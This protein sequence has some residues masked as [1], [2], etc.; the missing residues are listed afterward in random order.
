MIANL[1]T[2]LTD[3]AHWSGSDGIPARI[4]EHLEYSGIAVLIALL[5]AVPAGLYIGHTGRGTVAVASVANALRALPT[6]GLLVLAVLLL[7]PRLSGNLGFQ[8][9]S[10]LVLVIL[11]IPPILTSTYAG[12]Q[13]VDPSARDA[14]YGIGMT[15]R[16]VLWQVEL[17]NSLPLM[18]SGFRSAVLQVVATATVA[19][20]VSLGGL[21]R[22]VIDG[23]QQRDYPQ[24]LSGAVLVALLAVVLDVLLA[25]VQRYAIP[26]GLTGRYRRAPRRPALTASPEP[27]S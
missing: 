21:G 10:I 15:G 7:L 2:W 20:Y 22:F 12:V 16:E 17:P 5:I 19:A 24:M 9:P 25:G 6:V 8:A 1:V 26:R 11:A 3:P 18:F 14:A 13:Q 4:A 27:N 23:Q